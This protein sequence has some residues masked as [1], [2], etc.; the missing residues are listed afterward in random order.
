MWM[1]DVRYAVRQLIRIP[2]FTVVASL[3]LALGIGAS[4]LIF[5]VVDGV[6]LRPV[7]VERLDRVVMAWE[8][9]RDSGTS[10]EPGSLPDFLDYRE[11]S[12]RLGTL[13]AFMGREVNHTP[14]DGEPLRLAALAVTHEFLPLIGAQPVIGRGFTEDEDRAGG[15]AVA[16]IGEG[17]W[18]NVFGRSP[19]VLGRTLDIDDRPVT[20][21]GVMPAETDFGVFQILSAADYSRS[22]ADR[23]ARSRVDVWLPLQGDPEEYPRQTH[24]VLMIGRLADG[25]SV[26]TAQDELETIAADLERVYPENQARGVRIESLSEVVFGPTRPAMMVLLAAVALLLIVACANV[27]NLLLARAASR[28]H[29]VAV[30]AAIGAGMR[31][32]TC[33]F[34]AESLVLTLGAAS[35]GIA[36]AYA[37]LAVLTRMAPAGIPRLV[38]VEIDGRVLAVTAAVSVLVGVIFGMLPAVQAWRSDVQAPLKA[39]GARSGTAGRL[40]R[41][42]RSGLVVAELG[43]AVVLVVGA[44][45]LMKSFWRLQAVDPGFRAARILKAE[46]QLPASRYPVDFS[47][48]PDFVEIHT[49]TSRLEERLLAVPGVAA[50]SIAGNHPLDPGFTNSFAVV[51]R[52]AEA[53]GWPEITVRRITPGY[54]DTVGVP[55]ISGRFLLRSDRV[56]GQTVSV[57]NEAA[58]A[59]FFGDRDPLGQAIRLWG[60]ARTI[61]GVIGD[62]RMHGL[63][64]ASPPAVYLPLAQAPT[65]GAGVVLV[66]GEG[67]PAALTSALRGAIRELDPALAVFGLEPLVETVARSVSERRFT[68][69]LL[70]SFA[71]VALLLAL[72]G[73]HGVLGYTVTERTREIGIRMALGARP[74]RV[75]RLV[76]GQ[77]M[78]MAAIGIGVGTLAAWLLAR[79][80]ASLLFG[81]EPTDPP[82]FAI[83]PVALALVALVASALPARRATKV[84]PVTA[85]RGE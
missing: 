47:K 20:V 78:V 82:T 42:V 69:V 21:I 2:S 72:V 34:L 54:F 15:P 79:F 66:R 65:T 50:V 80:I 84:E 68:M 61:V 19:D 36:L 48:W 51:G 71:A 25:A 57:I 55:L 38:E 12:T 33:Q 67:D 28:R 5:S 9:D 27:A 13:A 7:P 6:L 46:F 23:G 74:G 43:L 8:T 70:G 24:P 16:L 58:A 83:V 63:T 3:T 85:L 10:H 17:L 59:R 4:T 56:D 64:V 40:A 18:T 53:R 39:D 60:A 11:R 49:F 1:H 77:G 29:E 14:T 75:L 32:L 35:I 76:I 44:V 41:H 73:I 31:R 62:E 30:R 26:E 81:I 52:E 37:G 45:L 22:F